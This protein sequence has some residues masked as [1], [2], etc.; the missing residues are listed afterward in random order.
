MD[1]FKCILFLLSDL[2]IQA[3][4]NFELVLLA[5][6]D[7]NQ[8]YSEMNTEDWWW[9]TQDHILAGATIV[10]VIC[11]S[12]KTPMTNLLGD[13]HIWPPYLTI[14]DIRKDICWTPTRQAW[15]LVRHIPCPPKG[16][17]NIDEAWYNAV[18]TVLSQ[19]RHLCITGT[20]LKWDGADGLQGQCYPLLA[21]WV[22]DYPAQVMVAQVSYG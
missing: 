7:C 6:S 20:G 8:I 21:A 1:I 2:Q 19:L 22:E 14:G 13:Q 15:M 9:D 4:L 18:G 16:A 5:D 10:P 3:N 12:D 17:K 11:A